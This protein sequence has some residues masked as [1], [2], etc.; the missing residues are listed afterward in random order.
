MWVYS[1]LNN[2]NKNENIKTVVIK[3]SNSNTNEEFSEVVNKGIQFSKIDRFQ[4]EEEISYRKKQIED[5]I[6]KLD[7]LITNKNK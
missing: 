4:A 2:T 3:D 5:T 1:Y 7:D 6:S